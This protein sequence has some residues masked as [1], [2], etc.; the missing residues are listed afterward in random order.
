MSINIGKL[1][2]LPT[3]QR[4]SKTTFFIPK[5]PAPLLASDLYKKE[6]N[7]S[8]RRRI[9]VFA[10]DENINH[11]NIEPVVELQQEE[12]AAQ[13]AHQAQ[14]LVIQQQI[15]YAKKM[16]QTRYKAMCAFID[17][18]V[19]CMDEPLIKEKL[20]FK[21]NL[22][23]SMKPNDQDKEIKRKDDLYKVGRFLDQMKGNGVIR[24]L[25]SEIRVLESRLEE[26]STP[27]SPPTLK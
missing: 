2:M 8:R 27:V 12:K 6:V 14:R 15:D 25:N 19:D 20:E 23:Q 11:P 1:K 18:P 10:P 4:R 21:E 26:T 22:L 5:N 13:E 9:C 3:P 16:L 17:L 7:S 24:T